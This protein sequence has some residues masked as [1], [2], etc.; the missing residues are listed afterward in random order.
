MANK[1]DKERQV[2]E[3]DGIGK[4]KAED[5]EKAGITSVS[6]LLKADAEKLADK[7]GSSKK[8]IKKYQKKAEEL[9]SGK[10]K[11]KKK[12]ELKKKAEEL[13]KKISSDEEDIKKKLEKEREKLVPVKE[14]LKSG[15]YIGTK[16]VTPHMRP[17]VYKRRND[18][19]AT[20]DTNKTDEGIKEMIKKISKYEPK[21]FIVV[22]KREVG[23][24]AVK[25]FSEITGVRVFTK[26]YP[27]GILTNPKLE[28][29]FETEMVFIV[30][31][32]VDKNALKDANK[33][34]KKV[35]ALCD[36]NNYSFGVDS[37]IPCNNKSEKSLNLIFYLLT[38]GY[39]E[40]R[41]I[42]KKIEKEDF[43]EEDIQ[44]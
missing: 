10:S 1:K 41:G 40:E 34:K 16:A 33:M 3:I 24:K 28:D 31:P 26:K 23:W 20:I 38:K 39:V 15:I 2:S 25:K 21:D 11:E 27:A 36:T 9:T 13:K 22:C 18:G 32:W 37:F 44:G 14:Y 12:E 17:Y 30:D 4:K 7:V 8:T 19:I 6:K 5:L 35:F 42:D 29:F 43:I